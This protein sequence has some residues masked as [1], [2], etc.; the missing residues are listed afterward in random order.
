MSNYLPLIYTVILGKDYSFSRLHI[1]LWSV[2]LYLAHDVHIK[3]K[4]NKTNLNEKQKANARI[5]LEA[6]LY[7]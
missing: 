6:F 1:G 7:L 2:Y 4:E 3:Q 5:N